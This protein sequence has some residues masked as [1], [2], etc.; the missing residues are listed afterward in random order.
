MKRTSPIVLLLAILCSASVILPPSVVEA[1]CFCML[2]PPM[3][4]TS[5]SA[6][7]G[8]QLDPSYNPASAVV[9]VRDG[10]RTVLTIEAAYEGPA[11]EL[12]MVVPIP[13]SIERDAVRTI[14]GT[15][16]RRLDGRTAPR[17]RH[18]WPRCRPR[19]SMRGLAASADGFGGGGESLGRATAPTPEELGIEIQDEWPVAEYDV[20]LLGAQESTGLLTFLRQRG[21]E[22]PDRAAT[23]LR[24]YIETNHRFVL[25]R[26]DPSRAQRLGDAMMLSPIQIEY[27]SDQLV[28]PVRLGTLNSPGEQEVLL[29]VLSTDGRYVVA[30]RPNVDAP[31]DLRMRPSARGS[32]AELYN[33]ISDEIFRRTPGAAITEY[34]HTVGRHVRMSDVTPFG[35]ANDPN[36][37]FRSHADAARRWTVT[38]I[39]HRYGTDLRDDLVLQTA[40]APLR[41]TRRWRTSSLNTWAREGESAYHVQYVVEHTGCATEAQQ[42]SAARR[43]ATAESMWE[44]RHD[45]WPGEV[46]LDRVALLGIEPGSSAP[47]GWPPAPT[48]P[49]TVKPEHP[50]PSAAPSAPLGVAPPPSA[51]P[52]SPRADTPPPSAAAPALPPPPTFGA[53]GA[54]E[55]KSCSVGHHGDAPLW[56]FALALAIAWRRR[57][58]VG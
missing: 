46:L 28:V 58:R 42:R 48:P 39:R 43:F 11:V 23:M 24:G 29:Y 13:S 2:R 44:A 36:Q 14:T 55:T 25:L 40:S 34:A 52:T 1:T 57:R 30:N 17:V 33:A 50:V 10:R 8:A 37:V 45:L 31:T 7:A 38:R 4:A 56:L 47:A 26:A 27:D 41:M 35:V 19:P 12:S 6:Q 18:V 5:T 32:M 51:A 53:A 22:L 3:P 21:L 20:T 9:I 16:F 54:E 49:P 15:A